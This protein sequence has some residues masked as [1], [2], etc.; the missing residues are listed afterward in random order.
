MACWP[1]VLCAQG[2]VQ[3]VRSFEDIPM[4]P[5]TSA[6]VRLRYGTV[7]A[8]DG[9]TVDG[10]TKVQPI[11][12]RMA[13][14]TK[15]MMQAA[16]ANAMS[17]GPRGGSAITPAAGQA[18]G[19]MQQTFG[20]LTMG[21][22]E[23]VRSYAATTQPIEDRYDARVVDLDTT[24]YRKLERGG[25]M[26]PVPKKIDC[27]AVAAER[28]QAILKAG[29]AFLAEIAGPYE[30]H[31]AKVK[32]LA[33]DAQGTLDQAHKAFGGAPPAYARGIYQGMAASAMNA[34]AQAVDAESD[35][36]ALVYHKSVERITKH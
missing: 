9:K 26:D 34:L 17:S 5:K 20:R 12:D 16:M 29:D 10:D 11:D 7:T 25:C 31:K 27:G 1:A 14:W 3:I 32:G 23:E 33:A 15:S 30:A 28:D 24:Y 35:I 2:D 22:S 13:A 4:L 21:L 18:L 8:P 19:A 6:E 36:V